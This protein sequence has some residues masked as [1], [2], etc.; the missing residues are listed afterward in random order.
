MYSNTAKFSRKFN[1]RPLLCA[2]FVFAILPHFPAIA[3]SDL[4]ITS[5]TYVDSAV[6]MITGSLAD[7]QDKISATGTDNLLT[8]PASAG[9]QPGTIAKSAF[10]DT[11]STQ[12][13]G[14]A[15]TF[16]SIPMIPTAALPSPQ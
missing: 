5:K 4:V 9:G 8:A 1:F 16:S 12:T 11:S 6:K 7:K 10:A 15:K 13:I 14:G 3:D 2:A